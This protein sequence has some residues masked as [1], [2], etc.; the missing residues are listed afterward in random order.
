MLLACIIGHVSLVGCTNDW[1]NHRSGRKL[2]LC[3]PPPVAGVHLTVHS[4]TFR[5]CEAHW[6]KNQPP[7]EWEMCRKELD[8]FKN[9]PVL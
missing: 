8:T 7:L 9:I 1:H 2:I 3:I 4:V 6:F 5:V